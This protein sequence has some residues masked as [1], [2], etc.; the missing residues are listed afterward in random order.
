MPR[1]LT[2]VPWIVAWNEAPPG[3]TTFWHRDMPQYL[4]VMVRV[5][6]TADGLAAEA[7]LVARNDGRAVTARDLRSV[8]IPQPWMLARG[9]EFAWPDHGSPTITAVG[10][11]ARSKSDDHWRAVF[12]LWSRARRTAPRS[13]IKWM[14]AQR[15]DVSDATMRRWVK[16]ARERAKV[17]GWEEDDE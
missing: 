10:P 17:N 13:P 14:L 4:Q 15:P 3:W 9:R 7:V 6:R 16:R 11:G 1:D 8:K 5:G 12:S 2:D